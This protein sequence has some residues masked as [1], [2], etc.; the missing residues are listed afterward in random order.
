MK[1]RVEM[2]AFVLAILKL[3]ASALWVAGFCT[4]ASDMD[5]EVAS[6]DRK[7]VV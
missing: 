5:K 1:V 4:I 6:G 7:S 3:A 2:G